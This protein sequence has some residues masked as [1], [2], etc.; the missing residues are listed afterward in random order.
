M[1][2][3]HRSRRQCVSRGPIA[4]LPPSGTAT[5][6]RAIA[7]TLHLTF[8][9]HLDAPLLAVEA[10]LLS[11]ASVRDAPHALCTIASAEL[12]ALDDRGDT[13]T[14]DAHFHLAPGFLPQVADQLGGA[15]WV[16][17]VDWIRAE[18]RGSFEVRPDLPAA[19]GR[20]V[21][22][23]GTYRLE[24]DPRGG[25][26]RIIEGELSV[27]V[28]VLGRAIEA[29]AAR[30]LDVHFREEAAFLGARSAGAGP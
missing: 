5:A 26:R 12:L 10:A 29:R 30:M 24:A 22:C 13:L 4:A 6:H 1:H 16:E 17:H 20:R 15:G 2:G 25:T 21:R 23:T 7:V 14:R 27:R 9:H 8:E 11:P 3:L 19:L 28:P 18:H